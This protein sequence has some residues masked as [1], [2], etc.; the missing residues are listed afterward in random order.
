MRKVL[1]TALLCSLSLTLWAQ[2][3]AAP[4]KA[5]PPFEVVTQEETAKLGGLD[6]A[7]KLAYPRFTLEHK[8]TENTLNRFIEEAMAGARQEFEKPL[9][10][11]EL[12]G[13]VAFSYSYDAEMTVEEFVPGKFVSLLI[14]IYAYSGGAHGNSWFI[15]H[16]LRAEDG[17]VEAVRLQ[18]LFTNPDEALKAIE[19]V[20]LFDLTRQDAGWVMSGSVSEITWQDL[21][22]WVLL[23]QEIR[24]IFPPYAMGPYAQGDFRVEI[25]HLV[26]R[27]QINADAWPF[28][29][30]LP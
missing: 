5:K 19:T 22:S 28:P 30:Y 9:R 12:P 26:L 2:E 24:F 15:T 11:T 14:T 21:G 16:N 23:D 18:D 29:P 17:G 3:E 1:L 13:D 27:K 4:R 8:P 20:C 25:P 10:D 7:Y 6:Y